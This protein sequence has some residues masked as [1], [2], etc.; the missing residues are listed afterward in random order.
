MQPENRS[1]EPDEG[2]S[3]RNMEPAEYKAW[4]SIPQETPQPSVGSV[5]PLHQPSA[6]QASELYPN[7]QSD[8]PAYAPSDHT[9]THD[10]SNEDG[11]PK[12]PKAPIIILASEPELQGGHPNGN[13]NGNGHNDHTGQT[14]PQEPGNT[15]VPDATATPLKPDD[16]D[17]VDCPSLVLPSL[18][19]FFLGALLSVIGL[20][21]G[22]FIYMR[23]LKMQDKQPFL[24]GLIIGLIVS[25]VI[26]AIII[27]NETYNY[28]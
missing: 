16:S 13:G 18:A 25:I 19:G 14:R 2:P 9:A 27:G 28:T 6:P 24:I 12:T 5:P 23:K 4:Y 1:N 3:V 15:G 17:E 7:P 26:I 20:F 8:N 10:A 21:V 22:L 11:A